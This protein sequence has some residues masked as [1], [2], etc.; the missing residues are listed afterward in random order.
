M[1]LDRLKTYSFF[2]KIENNKLRIVGN[3]AHKKLP[4]FIRFD[5][6]NDN[7]EVKKYQEG[8][9]LTFDCVFL[10]HEYTNTE[11]RLVCHSFQEKIRSTDYNTT[12]KSQ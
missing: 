8:E 2:G 7:Q 10:Y 5:S 9:K 3:Y 4:T 6:K 12:K 11:H 1:N